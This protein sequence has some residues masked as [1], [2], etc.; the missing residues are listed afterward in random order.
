MDKDALA[1]RLGAPTGGEFRVLA[2]EPYQWGHEL[3]LECTYEPSIGSQPIPFQIRL[4]DC[5][6]MQWRLYAHLRAPEDQAAT[7]AML[8][9]IHLG[10]DNHRKPLNVLTDFFGL[11]V[12]YGE[13]IIQKSG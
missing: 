7:T 6:E 1:E 12:S 11:T 4:R 3:L 10:R 9:N 2:I 5:R 13:L 8:V